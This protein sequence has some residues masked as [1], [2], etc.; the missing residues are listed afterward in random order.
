MF[1][2]FLND[3]CQAKFDMILLFI[4]RITNKFKIKKMKTSSNKSRKS[5]YFKQGN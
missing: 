2:T 1:R 4:E 3:L 5:N